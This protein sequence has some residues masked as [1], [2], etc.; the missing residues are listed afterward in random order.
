VAVPVEFEPICG[1]PIDLR[2]GCDPSKDG[3]Y[4]DKSGPTEPR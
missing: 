3:D 4:P 1:P 2:R